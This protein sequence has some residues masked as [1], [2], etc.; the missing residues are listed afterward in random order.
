MKKY[1]TGINVNRMSKEDL[2][3]KK[4]RNKVLQMNSALRQFSRHHWEIR[5]D[6]DGSGYIFI[7]TGDNDFGNTLPWEIADGYELTKEE[8]EHIKNID[9]WEK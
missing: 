5:Q 8:L 9:P 1:I 6:E 4:F 7:W 3:S 2:V